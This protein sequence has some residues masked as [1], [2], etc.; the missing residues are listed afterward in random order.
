MTILSSSPVNPTTPEERALAII[1]GNRYLTLATSDANGPWVCPLAYV[2]LPDN[3]LVFYSAVMARHSEAISINPHIA[4]AIYDSQVS[5]DDADGVQFSGLCT[6]VP[7]EELDRV[8]LTYF[9]ISFPDPEI[10]AR[11][12]RPK[13]DFISP[14]P[15]RF[16]RIII[17][18]A[19]VPDLS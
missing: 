15:Q 12:T 9:N 14:A 2:W 11:W 7:P 10:Q 6:E 8:I 18:H 17:K 19:Y 13:T 1:T 16:Y 3:S 4:G 5:S